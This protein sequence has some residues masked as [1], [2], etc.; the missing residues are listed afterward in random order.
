MQELYLQDEG[1]TV[2]HLG[3]IDLK[4]FGYDPAE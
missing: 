1:V 2:N 3:M 4:K